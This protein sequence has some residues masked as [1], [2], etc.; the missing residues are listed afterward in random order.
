[1]SEARIVLVRPML[2]G[3]RRMWL[4]EDRRMGIRV[5]VILLTSI[6]GRDVDALMGH[7]DAK[8]L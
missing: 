4:Y 7:V 1:M 3:R 5:R 6:T 8:C 2:G